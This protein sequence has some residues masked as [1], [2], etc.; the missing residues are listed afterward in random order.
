MPSR[1]AVIAYG[2]YVP[3]AVSVGVGLAL[4]VAATT[5]RAGAGAEGC[6]VPHPWIRASAATKIAK[7]KVRMVERLLN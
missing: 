1:P 2:A 3:T 5:D 6:C 4:G 7:V